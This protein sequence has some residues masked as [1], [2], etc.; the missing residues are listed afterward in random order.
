MIGS[1]GCAQ[2]SY[3]Q[4]SPVE[5][6]IIPNAGALPQQAHNHATNHQQKRKR[7]FTPPQSV[8]P[9]TPDQARDAVSRIKLKWPGLSANLPAAR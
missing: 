1:G 4:N 5:P 2:P 6:R 8:N 3:R 9:A 7:S